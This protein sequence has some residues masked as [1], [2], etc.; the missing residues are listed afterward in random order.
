MPDSLLA[1]PCLVAA[2][3]RYGYPDQT[4][5][6]PQR[7]LRPSDASGR[8]ERKSAAMAQLG[9]Y[10]SDTARGVR[11]LPDAAA[12]RQ[13]SVEHATSLGVS[14]HRQSRPPTTSDSTTPDS[15]AELASTTRSCMGTGPRAG[16]NIAFKSS[17]SI[18][19]TRP[20]T[21][22]SKDQVD[23]PK[24]AS[25]SASMNPASPQVNSPGRLPPP[26]FS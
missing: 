15:T 11:H 23:C 25:P 1:T 3:E 5:T 22:T 13:T 26:S 17:P 21:R 20:L 14:I 4:L 19:P 2:D 16:Q 6:T 24:I 12:G 18:R 9:R 7:S 10:W 8:C